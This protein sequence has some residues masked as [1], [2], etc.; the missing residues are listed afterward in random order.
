MTIE[1]SLIKMRYLCFLTQYNEIL[2]LK[3]IK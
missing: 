3:Y 1:F 2:V